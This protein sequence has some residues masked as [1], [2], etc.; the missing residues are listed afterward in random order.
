MRALL[1][2]IQLAAS[3]RNMMEYLCKI[4]RGT[5]KFDIFFRLGRSGRKIFVWLLLGPYARAKGSLG[6]S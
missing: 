4:E 1:D 5:T 3:R 6:L 2:T